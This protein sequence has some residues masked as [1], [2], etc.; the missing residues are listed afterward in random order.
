MRGP[1]AETVWYTLEIAYTIEARS[2]RR[3]SGLFSCGLRHRTQRK[4]K[5]TKVRAFYAASPFMY[6][7]GKFFH[8]RS[9]LLLCASPLENSMVE[10]IYSAAPNKK[11]MWSRSLPSHACSNSAGLCD[12]VEASRPR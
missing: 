12:R 5:K 2:P 3:L 1:A 4:N 6:T 7:R 11:N 10:D 9:P 8:A